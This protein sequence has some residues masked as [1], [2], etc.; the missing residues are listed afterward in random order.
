MSGEC[1]AETLSSYMQQSPQQ[2]LQ[3]INSSSSHC[4]HCNLPEKSAELESTASHS[5][6]NHTH[7]Q[8]IT[9]KMPGIRY[10]D[11]EELMMQTNGPHV[12]GT[13]SSSVSQGPQ[14]IG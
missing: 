13:L 12:M 10:K 1:T 4:V 6:S 14:V 9:G 7:L 3:P 2:V 5:L 11:F 8:G